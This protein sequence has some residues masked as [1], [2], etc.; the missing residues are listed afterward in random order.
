M[1]LKDLKGSVGKKKKEKLVKD[2]SGDDELYDL[3]RGAKSSMVIRRLD[4]DGEEKFVPKQIVVMVI[5]KMTLT[6][7]NLRKK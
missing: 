4:D 3:V 7:Q 5:R 6:N 2:D 1:V